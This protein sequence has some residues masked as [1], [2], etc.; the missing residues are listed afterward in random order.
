MTDQVSSYVGPYQELG[1]CTH[2]SSCIKSLACTVG[3]MC[4]CVSGATRERECIKDWVHICP[5]WPLSRF[6]HGSACIN[7]YQ[8]LSVYLRA[9]SR[10]V[11]TFLS[12]LV[13][14]SNKHLIL[15]AGYAAIHIKCSACTGRIESWAC[16]CILWFLSRADFEPSRFCQL[17]SANHVSSC[18]SPHQGLSVYMTVHWFWGLSVHLHV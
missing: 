13:L 10:F 15:R 8:K 1:V 7:L 9:S 3:C 11:S 6:G 18:D 5:S 16:D 12:F 2:V 17:L 4:Q 14:F